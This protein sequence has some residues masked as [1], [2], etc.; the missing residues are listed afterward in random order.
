MRHIPGKFDHADRLFHD[1]RA[2]WRNCL[3]STCKQATNNKHKQYKQQTNRSSLTALLG[4]RCKADVKE[5]VPEFFVN[6][7]ALVIGAVAFAF[8]VAAAESPPPPDQFAK[9][10]FRHFAT[11]WRVVAAVPF[12]ALSTPP[13]KCRATPSTMCCC[14]LV[15]RLP[16]TCSFARCLCLYVSF[17]LYRR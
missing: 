5:L 2:T 13:S 15:R 3:T 17:F 11:S 16:S 10:R 7:E 14:P 4:V 8:R 12:S 1:L 6:G 9:N